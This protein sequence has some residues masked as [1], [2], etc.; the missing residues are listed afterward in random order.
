MLII[1]GH[2]LRRVMRS[3]IGWLLLALLI[4]IIGLFVF[5]MLLHQ[6]TQ[7]QAA[8]AAAQSRFGITAFVVASMYKSASFIVLLIIPSLCARTLSEERRSGA[9]VR[10]LAAPRRAL[11]IVLGK[12][13]AVFGY[14]LIVWGLISLMPL[15]L[16]LATPLD[17]GLWLSCLIGV[18][19]FSL[20]A[21]GIGLLCASAVAQP[22]LATALGLAVLLGL[23][24]LGSS[25]STPQ[26]VLEIGFRA[27]LDPM[28]RG[29]VSTKD[30]AYF[31]LT[32]LVAISF[33]SWRLDALRGTS[34][35][36]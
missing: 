19:L 26:A 4:A 12:F 23:W 9:L 8:L 28:F 16:L 7:Q 13:L 3:P 18:L 34:P 33:C 17:V 24:L 6:F 30:I 21:T 5:I 20:S 31:G 10:L 32:S 15:A 29:L 14:L 36:S 27:H 2:D 11:E 22:A 35:D 1:A 25:P